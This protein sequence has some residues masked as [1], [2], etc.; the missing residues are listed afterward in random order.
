MKIL[1]LLVVMD[2]YRV[3]FLCSL[4]TFLFSVVLIVL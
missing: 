3:S 2:V 4:H 1:S